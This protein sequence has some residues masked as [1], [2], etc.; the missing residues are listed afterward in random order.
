MGRSKEAYYF[1][2]DSNARHD[3]KIQQMRSEYKSQGYGWFWIIIEILRD[4]DNY[5]LEINSEYCWKA[6]AREMD[7][8][9]NKVKK[10]VEDCIEKFKLFDCDDDKK[11]F[12]SNSLLRRM[13]IKE[14]K[15][16]KNREAAKQRWEK[17]VNV[18]KDK[19]DDN[20]GETLEN[21]EL[22]F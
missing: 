11:F 9:E 8:S 2:H 20:K 4:Q 10:F 14:E 16:E 13:A 22:P 17:R 21:E 3:P 12:W 1:S 19:N 5:K 6:L 15:S 7:T 18:S